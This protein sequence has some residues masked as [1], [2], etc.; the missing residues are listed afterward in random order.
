MALPTDQFTSDL[1]ATIT[2]LPDTIV[3]EGDTIS[4]VA[5]DLTTAKELEDFGLLGDRG[6]EIH[7]VLAD[8]GTTPAVGQTLTARGL[9]LRIERIIDDPSSASIRLICME[10][11]R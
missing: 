10:D 11:D 4:A 8:F 6:L 1:R 7:A 3:H 9:T 2:D 5:G